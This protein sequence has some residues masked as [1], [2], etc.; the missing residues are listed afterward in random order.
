M[1]PLRATPFS[2]HRPKFLSVLTSQYRN[3]YCYV[4]ESLTTPCGPTSQL[5]TQ[6]WVTS[7]S[8]FM[9]RHAQKSISNTDGTSCLDDESCPF[10]TWIRLLNNR[11]PIYLYR[12]YI[13]CSIFQSSLQLIVATR[14]STI[15]SLALQHIASINDAALSFASPL[16]GIPQ[17]SHF[18]GHN[19]DPLSSLYADIEFKSR[20]IHFISQ[21]S[22]CL[23][24]RPHTHL[25]TRT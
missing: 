1:P 7:H 6:T 12:G 11:L 18:F 5:A 16:C 14:A 15:D 24:C 25:S 8:K 19:A 20:F 13:R 10:A 4:D 22:S 2:Q 23:Y 21:L 3:T 9:P 17:E